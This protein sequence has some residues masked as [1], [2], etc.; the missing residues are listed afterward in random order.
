MIDYV[1]DT[2]ALIYPVVF[3][4]SVDLCVNDHFYSEIRRYLVHFSGT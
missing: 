4:Y 1:Y 3:M 2:T